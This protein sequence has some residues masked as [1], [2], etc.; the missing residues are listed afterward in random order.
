MFD[1]GVVDTHHETNICGVVYGPSFIEIENKSN[2]RMY[3]NGAVFSGA[4]IYLEGTAGHPQVFRYDPNT[5]DQLAVRA[6]IG[7]GLVAT[8]FTIRQ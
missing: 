8:G 2:Q 6:G 5:I 4:G 7:T 3:F 1:N